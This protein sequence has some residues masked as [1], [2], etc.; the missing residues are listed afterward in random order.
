MQAR[1]TAR[2]S[3][4][5]TLMELMLSMS[6]FSVLGVALISLLSTS[7]NMLRD[8][9][10]NVETMDAMQL[11]SET[12]DEDIRTLYTQRDSE[13]DTPDVRLFADYAG[14]DIDEDGKVD[15]QIQRLFFTRMIPNEATASLTRLAGSSV[16]A[17]GYLDQVDDRTEAST[18]ALRATGGLMEVFW[19]AIPESQDDL[20]ILRLYRGFRSPIG[21][22]DSLLPLRRTGA[23]SGLEDPDFNPRWGGK[24]PTTRK[25]VES[26]AQPVVSGV[27]YFGE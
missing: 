25:E 14:S 21:G 5:F 15:G 6:L 24:G 7:S 27:L 10:S 4:G 1:A 3:A 2:R 26:I 22:Q 17:D 13:S 16:G 12:F 18:G 8:G 19:A 23:G 11:F 20:A 9:A